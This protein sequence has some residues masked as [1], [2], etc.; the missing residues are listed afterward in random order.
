M[1]CFFPAGSVL[2]RPLGKVFL[3]GRLL[4]RGRAVI[5]PPF[6]VVRGWVAI[7]LCSEGIFNL[8]SE[9]FFSLVRCL[10]GLKTTGFMASVT[11][12]SI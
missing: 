2:N 8:S 6:R 3:S 11:K 12:G 9:T 5:M 7:I 4:L 10:I 1:A